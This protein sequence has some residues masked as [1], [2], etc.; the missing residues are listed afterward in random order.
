M[1]EQEWHYKCNCCGWKGLVEEAEYDEDDVACC[2][3]CGDNEL[4]MNT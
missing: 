4:E 1:D 2:P 3:E